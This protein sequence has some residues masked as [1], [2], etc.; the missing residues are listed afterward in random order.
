[1]KKVCF[2][3]SHLGSGSGSLVAALNGHPQCQIHESGTRYDSPAT[4]RWLFRVGHKCRDASA[5]YG[6]HLLF[7]ASVSSKKIYASCMPIIVVRPARGSLNDIIASGYS[8]EGAAAYYRFRIRR[9]CEMAS[10]A[11][12][13]L[14]LTWDD[15]AKDSSMRIIEEYLG[16]SRPVQTPVLGDGSREVCPERLVD[17]CQR[18][19]D[20]YYYYLS[21]LDLRRPLDK[22]T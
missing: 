4:F 16:L 22:T 20:R 14:F 15:L 18:A 7:N 8:P 19:Y 6:D 10:R 12:K 9:I 21:N 3:V 11:R 17:E 2:V 5:V 1:L 13:P